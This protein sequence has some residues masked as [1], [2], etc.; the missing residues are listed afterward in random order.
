VVKV[1]RDAV[2][3][4]AAE[5]PVAESTGSLAGGCPCGGVRYRLDGPLRGVINCCCGQCRRSSG[6]HVAA[7]RVPLEGFSLLSA[8]T[9]SWYQSSAEA[10]RGF[11]HRC[12]GN[13]FWRHRDRDSISVMAGTL[14]RPTGLAT[15]ENIFVEEMGDYHALPPLTG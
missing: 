7:T 3:A 6:H 12:G 13:L 1:A 14:D 4:G 10:R 15:I 5:R 8:E 9:L 11:C 2:V